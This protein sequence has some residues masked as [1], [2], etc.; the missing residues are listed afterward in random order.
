MY[1]CRGLGGVKWGGEGEEKREKKRLLARP[2]IS[3]NTPSY[4]IHVIT[5][6][7]LSPGTHGS[8]LTTVFKKAAFDF[9]T[10]QFQAF[11]FIS[12][13]FYEIVE[14]PRHY[15]NCLCRQRGKLWFPMT[16]VVH[17]NLINVFVQLHGKPDKHLTAG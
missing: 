9:F 5:Y 10:F 3:G 14:S 15:L 7:A 6:R 12:V 13:I 8:R 1:V 4:I 11:Y 17:C 16:F 2:V